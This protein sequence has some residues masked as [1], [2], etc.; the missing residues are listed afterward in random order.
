MMMKELIQRTWERPDKTSLDG[1]IVK[2]T[3]LDVEADADEL[4]ASSHGHADDELV[5][6]YMSNGPFA[7]RDAM[8]D[9]LRSVEASR[10]PLFYTVHNLATGARVGQVSILN[11]MPEMGRAE[12][13][14]IWYDRAAQR[15]RVNTESIFLL[16]R[17]LFDDLGYRRVEWKCNALNEPSRRAA[18]RL[19]FSFEGLFRQHMVIKGRNRD[20]AWFAMMDSEWPTVKANFARFFAADDVSLA[21]LNQPIVERGATVRE[22]DS[23]T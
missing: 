18:L 16:L 5:W 17:Y 2:L 7:N 22:N 10:D 13:G 21:A 3:R 11:I 20:T 9:W 15:T 6:R 23:R 19:G 1:H 14:N 4:F 8:R 12:L